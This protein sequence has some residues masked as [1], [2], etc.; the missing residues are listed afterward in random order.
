MTRGKDQRKE[1]DRGQ[2]DTGRPATASPGREIRQPV[3][4]PGLPEGHGHPTVYTN[5]GDTGGKVSR[6]FCPTCG[7]R[8]YTSGDHPGSIVIVQAGSPNDPNAV[9]PENVIYA[10][11]TPK[12]DFFDREI[13]ECN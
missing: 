4:P 13:P 7:G 2:Q 10:G 11:D 12:W 3:L 9:Y 5:E 6:H 1:Q 8:L